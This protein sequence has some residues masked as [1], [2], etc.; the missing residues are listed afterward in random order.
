MNDYE[1]TAIRGTWESE[2]MP[3]D[4]RYIPTME[5]LEEMGDYFSRR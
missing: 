4:Y 3:D 5:E 2:E 1:M